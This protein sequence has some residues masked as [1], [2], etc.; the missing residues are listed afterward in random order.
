MLD[1]AMVLLA[2]LMGPAVAAASAYWHHR[3]T[4]ADI[5]RMKLQERKESR[6]LRSYW[7]GRV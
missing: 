4:L 3:Q 5:R 2:C 7:K 1:V 6:R